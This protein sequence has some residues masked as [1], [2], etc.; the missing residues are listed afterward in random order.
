MEYRPFS[1]KYIYER[2]NTI[3]S[4]SLIASDINSGLTFI[5]PFSL[6]SRDS[7]VAVSANQNLSQLM[8]HFDQLNFDFGSNSN[9]LNVGYAS[10]INQKL[11]IGVAASQ[12]RNPYLLPDR[13]LALSYEMKMA[14]SNLLGISYG[15][16]KQDLGSIAKINY[17]GSQYDF[18][19]FSL[20]GNEKFGIDLCPNSKLV[21]QAVYEKRTT[22]PEK[23]SSVNQGDLSNFGESGYLSVSYQ[24]TPMAKFYGSIHK[25]FSENEILLFNN[26]ARFAYL[27]A[28][29]SDLLVN[30][31]I[32]I[33]LK[34]CILDIGYSNS[35][36]NLSGS[37]KAY[38]ESL[39]DGWQSMFSTDKLA[40]FDSKFSSNSCN[41][42]LIASLTPKVEFNGNL[43]YF[44]LRPTGDVNI[45]NSMF[46]GMIKKLEGNYVLP[47]KRI[48]FL[49]GGIDLKYKFAPK[50]EFVYSFK[51]LIPISIDNPAN[52]SRNSFLGANN[53]IDSGNSGSVQTISLSYRY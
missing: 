50:Y 39:P 43:Q 18:P 12:F 28:L 37:G 51:Q 45:W 23:T 24:K 3:T 40:E 38:N 20:T 32:S 36:I 44:A 27:R 46:Y 49:F 21:L 15:N 14:I 34:K 42:S 30:V 4:P 33:N 22:Q 29:S 47:Y 11:E 1:A 6:F 25:G 13:S 19:L 17:D 53:D 48:D 2:E 8:G 9:T 31:G 35:S 41:I 26:Q 16:E 7:M 10:K 5:A 52:G